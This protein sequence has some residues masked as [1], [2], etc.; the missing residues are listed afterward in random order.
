MASW[1]W[2]LAQWLEIRWWQRYLRQQEVDTYLA[3]KKSYWRRILAETGLELAPMTSVLDA[4]CGPAGIFMILPGQQVTAVD[5]LINRYEQEL[6][7]FSSAHYPW[8]VFQRARIEVLPPNPVF[9]YVFCLNAINHVD[10]LS[11][12]L[13]A[14]TAQLAPGATLVLSVDSHRFSL[15]KYLFRLLPGDALHPHQHDW[16]EYQEMIR[17]RGLEIRYTQRIKRQPIFDYHLLIAQKP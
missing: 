9:D 3:K 15:V 12:A 6:P 2:R 4:G 1:R 14:L 8:V 11:R 17:A 5:P 16:R 13:D 10:D 7:H